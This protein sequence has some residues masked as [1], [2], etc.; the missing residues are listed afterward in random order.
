MKALL[1]LLSVLPWQNMLLEAKQHY[2]NYENDSCAVKAAR[3]RDYCSSHPGEKGVAEL[4]VDVE[5]VLGAL[6]QASG[7]RDSAALHYRNAYEGVMRMEDRGKAPMYCINLA[8]ILRQTGKAPEAAQW[9]RRALTLSD[10]LSVHE[11]DCAVNTQLGQVYSDLRNFSMAESYFEAAEKDCVAGSFDDY[12]LANAR[13]NACFFNG[14]YGRAISFFRRA[15]EVARQTGNEFNLRVTEI[16]LGECF[17]SLHQLDSAGVYIDSSYEFWSRDENS[18]DSILAAICGMKAGLALER[19]NL[20]EAER[21]ISA[22]KGRE[23]SPI[24]TDMINRHIMEISVL[25]GDWKR[26]Y[27]YGSKTKAYSDSLFR[28]AM[29]SNFVEA[30]MRYSRDTTV[31]HQQLRIAGQRAEIFRL[32]GGIAAALLGLIAC[33]LIILRIQAARKRERIRTE[34]II[35]KLKLE[36]LKTVGVGR[37]IA[38]EDASRDRFV[39]VDEMVLFTYLPDIRRWQVLLRDGT[40]CFMKRSS[41]AGRILDISPCFTR[42]NQQTIVNVDYI[43]SIGVKSQKC[44]L[45]EPFSNISLSFSRRSAKNVNLPA[46]LQ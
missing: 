35:N 20:K 19:N 23:T 25:K 29:A 28:S 31:L 39:S 33:V 36:N 43:K 37:K 2:M 24:Y 6:A 18:D 32:G 38:V 26:A 7:H 8:D 16:N 4:S 12:F 1:L 21:W 11:L 3:V 15:R 30:E 14:N 46:N 40:E 34:E 44:V 13:G 45:V 41:T 10:S 27:E 22:G 17:L 9:L 5:N 42:L